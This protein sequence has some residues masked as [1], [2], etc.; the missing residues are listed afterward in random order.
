MQIFV[1]STADGDPGG[2]VS[3]CRS[4]VLVIRGDTSYAYFGSPVIL[5][6]KQNP[7]PVSCFTSA[8][9]SS[10]GIGTH[11]C[12]SV[13]QATALSSLLHCSRP[14][15]GTRSRITKNF[16]S[17]TKKKGSHGWTST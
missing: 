3:I 6:V 13:V 11:L 8:S 9:V 1:T 14:V 2:T 10:K 5:N 15:V 4:I 16:D 7:F 12:A 17:P